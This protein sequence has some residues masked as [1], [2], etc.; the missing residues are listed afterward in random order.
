MTRPLLIK[1][2]SSYPVRKKVVVKHSLI[3]ACT[4]IA[5]I[6]GKIIRWFFSG[7]KLIA[8]AIGERLFL[9][10]IVHESLQLSFW[11]FDSLSTAGDN[12]VFL[13]K[14][15]N[16]FRLTEYW[17]FEIVIS[18][19]FNALIIYFIYTSIPKWSVLQSVFFTSSV[20]VLNIFS[21]TLAKEP[22]QMMIFCGFCYAIRRHSSVNKKMFSL[23]ILIILTTALFRAYYILMLMFLIILHMFFFV[24]KPQTTRGKSLILLAIVSGYLLFL[25]VAKYVDINIYNQLYYLKSDARANRFNT[26]ITPLFLSIGSNDFF[27][28][29]DAILT[30]LRLMFPIE[31]LFIKTTTGFVSTVIIFMYQLIVSVSVLKATVKWSDISDE[32][33]IAIE[34]FFAFLLMSAIFEPDFGS[35]MRHESVT[36]PILL[37]I[38]DIFKVK[39]AYPK[40]HL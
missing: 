18:V 4:I 38:S 27:L 26:G 3:Y 23:F 36:L 17:Q 7:E 39:N 5:M 30:T 20:G 25:I 16:I 34:C 31:L 2:A 19:V 11:E 32:K 12:T 35:W 21:F 29:I 10:Q 8:S 37:I 33:K 28:V 6:C 9:H 1:N 24:I 40:R 15:L 14:I 13:F 22:I